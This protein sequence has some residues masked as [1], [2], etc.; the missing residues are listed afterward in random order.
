MD[1]PVL[2]VSHTIWALCTLKQPWE[3]NVEGIK[4]ELEDVV[5]YL[6]YPWEYESLLKFIS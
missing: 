3:N 1:N 2:L 4:K 6:I 5:V